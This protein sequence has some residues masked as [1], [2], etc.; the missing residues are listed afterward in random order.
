MEK[1]KK[2]FFKRKWF[3][4]TA[5]IVVLLAALVVFVKMQSQKFLDAMSQGQTSV[6]AVTRGDLNVTITGS[7]TVEPYERY[8]IIPLVKGEVLASP[9]EEG[10]YVEKDALLYE[11]DHEDMD[12]AMT[13]A[14][15]S[16]EKAQISN[17]SN[18]EDLAKVKLYAPATGILSGFSVSRGDNLAGAGVKIG[19]IQNNK[20]LVVKVPFNKAQAD[21][22]AIGDAASLSIE[23]YMMKID[24]R[25]TDKA[26]YSTATG[27]GAMLY[28]VE[29][30]VENPGAVGS[31]TKVI[32]IVHTATG[33]VES[34]RAATA[35]FEKAVDLKTILGGEVAAVYVNDNQ[36]VTEGQLIL[37]IDS[38]DLQDRISQAN[39]DMRDLQLSV[40]SQQKQMEDYFIKSPISGTVIT[41]NAKTGDT[42]SQTTATTNVLMTVADMSKMKFTFNAD[43]LD[44]AKVSVGQKVAVTADALEN[45][46]FAGEVTKVASEGTSANGVTTYAVE[47]TINEPGD[48]KPGMNVNAEIIYD[49]RENVLQVPSSAI[50]SEKGKTYVYKVDDDKKGKIGV[51]TVG[52]DSAGDDKNK[53]A[54]GAPDGTTKVEVT[55][56][57]SNETMI[58][59]ISGL[60]EGDEVIL[61]EKSTGGMF[62]GMMMGGPGGG[63]GMVMM[64]A[65][66]AGGGG[67]G[68]HSPGM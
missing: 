4:I 51:G 30:T 17:K 7:G 6:Q 31:G 29:I 3:I 47:V 56:G 10:D 16:I 33:D 18:Q 45:V 68:G 43:E 40:E 60:S 12:I 28:D 22:I 63:N 62:G 52:S 34:P 65:A 66:P 2:P 53:N 50:F 46:E 9:Y 57:L 32:G 59:V 21:A 48:L 20:S 14:R 54:D 1:A 38:K 35:D 55:V 58:E 36:W 26:S 39:I 23:Q 44:I 25:V 19:S 61:N 24:G 11:I 64:E 5:I 27:D 42:L 67:P 15:N 8:D 41:K 49:S 37:E 13:K